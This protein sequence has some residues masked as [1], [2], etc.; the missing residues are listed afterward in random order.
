MPS[1]T[2]QRSPT[3]LAET[4]F[5]LPSLRAESHRS[6]TTAAATRPARPTLSAM[7]WCRP[8]DGVGN[9]LSE[10]RVRTLPDTSTETLVTPFVS[11]SLDR[12]ITT[13]AADGS[14]SSV[15]YDLLGKPTSRTDALSRV[16]SMTY[17]LMGRLVQRGYPEGTSEPSP[18]TP[19][20]VYSLSSIAAVAPPP[21]RTMR[22]DT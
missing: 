14:S 13:T 5:R 9:R 17:D 16:I 3:M 7:R 19:K 20:A 22:L 11:D 21:S 6:S 8:D 10:T 12:V 15:T 18:T 4:S 1:A 2:W